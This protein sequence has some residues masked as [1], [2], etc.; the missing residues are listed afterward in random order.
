MMR[1]R[2]SFCSFCGT[3][4]PDLQGYPRRCRAC[5][6]ETWANPI[7]VS[8]VLLPVQHRGRTGLLVVRRD[9]EPHRGFLVLVGGFVEE[10]E[11]WQSAA[12]REMREEAGVRIDPDSLETF[13][14]ASSSPYP[15]RVLL[16]ALAAPMASADLPAFAPSGKVSERGAVFGCAG[17]AELFAFP[18]HVQAA[19]RYFAGRGSA[20]YTPL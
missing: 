9:I 1:A 15:N 12:S 6:L 18:L 4:F 3:G 19:E 11:S 13:W 16:F 7:P 2:D 20:D 17:L 8:V 14:F 10:H 5:G